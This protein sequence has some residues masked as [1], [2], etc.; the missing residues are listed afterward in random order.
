MTG[1]PILTAQAMRTAEQAAIDAGDTVENLME[2]AGSALA[3]AIFQ[4]AG[5][6]PALILCGPGNN[7][8]D[9]YAA[10]RHLQARGV[11]VRVAALADPATVA[12]KWARGQWNG[13]VE[14]PGSAEPAPVLV[15]CLF[16]TGLKRPLGEK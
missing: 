3:E 12:A 9:G 13:A 11:P 15:D 16:G 14:D 4:Y 2:R 6:R 1:R 5:S 10:A 7:G 8:G